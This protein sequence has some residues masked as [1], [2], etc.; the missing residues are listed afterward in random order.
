MWDPVLNQT[1]AVLNISVEH[2]EALPGNGSVNTFQH[3]TMGAVFPVDEYYSSLLGSSQR[4]SELV[5]WRSRD[6]PNRGV[7]QQ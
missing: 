1:N 3:A 4:A 5:E 6:K 2:Y 7:S